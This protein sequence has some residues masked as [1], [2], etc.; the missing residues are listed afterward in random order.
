MAQDRGKL[1]NSL[2]LSFFGI[3]QPSLPAPLHHNTHKQSKRRCHCSSNLHPSKGMGKVCKGFCQTASQAGLRSSKK[4]NFHC[5]IR[6]GALLPWREAARTGVFQKRR[7]QG[8]QQE[9]ANL[10]MMGKIWSNK[11]TRRKNLETGNPVHDKEDTEKMCPE[12]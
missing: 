4:P 5:A 8:G 2:F 3:P 6:A 7:L 1:P 10:Q 11:S 12:M 9:L